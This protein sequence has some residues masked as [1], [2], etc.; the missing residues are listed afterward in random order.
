M[1]KK[2][3]TGSSL[4]LILALSFG[5]QTNSNNKKAVA[6]AAW[7]QAGCGSDDIH[8]D[9]KMDK[10]QHALT[11]PATGKALVYV[12]EDD[13]TG[14]GLPTTRV[15]FDGKWAGANVP[16]SYFFAAV[17]PGVHRLCLN[18]QGH[19]KMGAARDFTAETGKVYFFLAGIAASGSEA[20]ALDEVPEA[21]GHFLIASHGLGTSAVRSRDEDR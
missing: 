14:G 6:D 12:F 1:R 3:L 15:G 17:T 4:F 21:E 18:W 8:F 11:Q 9:V 2:I 19:P 16:D 20:F 10:N 5:Q 13:L 7:R